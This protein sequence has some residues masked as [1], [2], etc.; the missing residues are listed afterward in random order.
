VQLKG[1]K[2]L[3][4]SI[5]LSLVWAILDTAS[6]ALG[7]PKLTDAIAAST[8]HHPPAWYL[9]WASLLDGFFDSALRLA[10]WGNTIVAGCRLAGF[11][12]LRNSYRPARGPHR[13]RFLESILLLLQGTGRR[14]S[15]SIRCICAA[16]RNTL[17]CDAIRDM[18]GGG[19]GVPLFHFVRDINVVREI[20]LWRAVTGYHVF[21]CYATLLSIG[22]GISQIRKVN[23]PRDLQ[24][25]FL[26]TRVLPI[27]GVILFFCV[28]EVFDD[29]PPTVPIR[30][31]LLFLTR[32]AGWSA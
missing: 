2:L 11:R 23:A 20:G 22:I 29:L 27:A 9:C 18:G 19:P 17:A 26:R 4:W 7:I 15:F 25:S 28:V 16:S 31:H 1:L 12:L 24:G 30:E 21:M 3:A 5:L 8:A 32:L 14:I 6:A 13:G 10:I